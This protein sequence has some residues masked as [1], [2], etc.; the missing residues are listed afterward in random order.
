MT[1]YQKELL[2]KCN[3][4]TEIDQKVPLFDDIYILPTKEKHE[5]GYK[6]MYIVGKV[7]KNDEYYLLD[8]CC[9][10]VN[11]GFFT[12]AIKEVNIDIEH[13]GIIHLWNNYQLFKCGYRVS[14]C[15]FEFVDREASND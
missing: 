12:K 7:R 15:T 13:A 4:R 14:S 2:E 1:K 9:D 11:L 10:V 6:I 3:V 5:S 8:T